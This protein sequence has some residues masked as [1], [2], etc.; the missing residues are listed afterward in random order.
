M[1]RELFSLILRGLAY[2]VPV[3]ALVILGFAWLV[4]HRQWIPFGLATAVIVGFLLGL[5]RW[6][7]RASQ[8]RYTP[9]PAPVT[10]WPDAGQQAWAEVDRFAASVEAAPPPIDD[11]AQVAQTER[12]AV[13]APMHLRGMTLHAVILVEIAPALDV[14]RMHVQTDGGRAEKGQDARDSQQETVHRPI[15]RPHADRAARDRPSRSISL[16]SMLPGAIDGNQLPTVCR[17]ADQATCTNN[18][19]PPQ[20]G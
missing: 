12:R 1:R 14:L 4:E 5:S 13:L 16:R 20:A 10:T 15:L 17:L 8:Q 3:L 18:G 6:L 7:A 2:A 9:T 11:L 19:I